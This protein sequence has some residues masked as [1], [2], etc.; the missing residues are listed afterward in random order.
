MSQPMLHKTP[1]EKIEE[2][3]VAAL[4]DGGLS[5]KFLIRAFPERP[6]AL[7]MSDV[8]K[9]ALV[10]YTGSRYTAPENTGSRGQMRRA[11]FAVHLYL[12]QATSGGRGLRELEQVRL[13]LQGQRIEG[14]DLVILRDGL[15]DQDGDLWRYV[16]EV[17][18]QLPAVPLNRAVPAPFLTDFPRTEGA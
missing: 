8:Q 7:D 3:I 5:A 10:Q 18:C 6:E 9:A 11:E 16:I 15:V 4:K 17:G 14:A 13:V 1:A 12:R 2:G